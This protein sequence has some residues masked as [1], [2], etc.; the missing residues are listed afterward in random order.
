MTDLLTAT[1]SAI[2]RNKPAET[3]AEQL[4]WRYQQQHHHLPWQPRR[5][6]HHQHYPNFTMASMAGEGP[7]HWKETTLLKTLHV[8]MSMIHEESS[9]DQSSVVWESGAAWWEVP[10]LNWKDTDRQ[11]R[12]RGHHGFLWCSSPAS[13]LQTQLAHWRDDSSRTTCSPTG[14]N[15][16]QTTFCSACLTTP[17]VLG[18]DRAHWSWWSHPET[19]G[20]VHMH[21]KA[22][23]KFREK[24]VHFR[25]PN[26]ATGPERE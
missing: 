6:R 11:I 8:S 18:C 15:C 19:G 4:D 21:G 14:L 7:G 10:G 25:Y 9:S 20:I 5:E 1:E 13:K 3:A 17:A 12:H 22:F 23:R 16:P 2:Q 24:I 26:P